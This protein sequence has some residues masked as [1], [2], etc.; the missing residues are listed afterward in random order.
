LG[1]GGAARVISPAELV[2]RVRLAAER[3][4]AVHW[5]DFQEDR[6][7]TGFQGIGSSRVAQGVGRNWPAICSSV[8]RAYLSDSLFRF[9]TRTNPLGT[10]SIL[11]FRATG[12]TWNLNRRDD[13]FAHVSNLFQALA[14]GGMTFTA[15]CNLPTIHLVGPSPLAGTV[16]V[17]DKFH[18]Q[19][20][21]DS[22]NLF[23]GLGLPLGDVCFSPLEICV[24]PGPRE[25]RPSHPV[26]PGRVASYSG[27]R[28]RQ[29]FTDFQ[30]RVPVAFAVSTRQSYFPVNFCFRLR[31]FPP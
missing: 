10:P 9:Y 3:I 11:I 5:A 15:I 20:G 21:V 17:D 4:R 28:S 29:L 8:A 27:S 24:S 30:H 18:G 22:E 25:N 26:I 19:G 31:A 12:E 13:C 23:D 6:W 7:V 14:L 2:G 1:W 16:A